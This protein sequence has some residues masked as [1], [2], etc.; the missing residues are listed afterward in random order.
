MSDE[1]QPVAAAAEPPRKP[2]RKLAF[3]ILSA[4]MAAV[5]VVIV[6]M[7]M[8][9]QPTAKGA[10]VPEG[11]EITVTAPKVGTPITIDGVK[12]GKT[13][14]AIKIRGRTRPIEIQGNGV[15][16]IVTPDRDQVVNLVP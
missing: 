13:P 9:R 3:I 16:K 5:L 7:V 10:D 2:S 14:Q 6:V 1:D 4:V 11:V 12:A 8:Q 15:T